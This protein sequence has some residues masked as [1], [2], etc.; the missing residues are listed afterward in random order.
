[1]PT[2]SHRLPRAQRASLSQEQVGSKQ[3]QTAPVHMGRQAPHRQPALLYPRGTEEGSRELVGT[4]QRGR[5]RALAGCG[6][7]ALTTQFSP[8]CT[9]LPRGPPRTS[10]VK[11]SQWQR[12]SELGSG[13]WG[14]PC[15]YP[16]VRNCPSSWAT[17]NR[18]RINVMEISYVREP[19]D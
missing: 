9:S 6:S 3:W 4:F 5:R 16:T 7:A 14:F 18:M 17:Q 8:R 2:F 19:S 12:E 1:M 10:H 11:V 15:V 13:K